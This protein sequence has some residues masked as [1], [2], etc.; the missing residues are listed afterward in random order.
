MYDL[1]YGNNGLRLNIVRVMIPWTAEPL[2]PDD[3]LRKKGLKYNWPDKNCQ[4]AFEG[5]EP[6]LKRTHAIVYAVPFSPPSKWKSDHRSTLGGKLLPQYYADY[7][8]YLADFVLYSARVR[9]INVDVLSLQNEPDVVA[10]WDSTR[11]TG[12]ELGT[13]LKLVALRLARQQSTTKIMM[14]EGST[15]DHSALLATPSLDNRDA[16]KYIGILASHSYGGYNAVEQGRGLLRGASERYM[17]PLWMSEYSIIGRPDDPGMEA[18]LRLAHTMY[19]DFAHGDASAWIY[20][21]S[22]FTH[23]FPGSMG[24][25][26]PPKD[27]TLV[28]PKRF[29]AFANY[30]RY[31]RPG[32]KRMRIDGLA[33]SNTGFVSPEGNEFVIVAI[34]ANANIDIVDSGTQPAEYNFGNWQISAVKAFSTSKDCDLAPF[35]DIL[36]HDHSF[37]ANLPSGSVTTFVGRLQSPRTTPN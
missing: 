6:A 5:L 11:W 33:F 15:W 14:P 16:R 9:H 1:L 19:L 10:P 7:A 20:C 37:Q 23:V 30:S 32:W 22:I 4:I 18:A 2:P 24:V 13:F 28:V 29:W 31:V 17:I 36:A 35:S 12:E 34:N 3:P 25:F 21:F 27:G 26:S 8:D